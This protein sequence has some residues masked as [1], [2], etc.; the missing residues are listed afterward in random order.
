MLKRVHIREYRSLLDLEL[1][2]DDVSMISGANGVGKSNCYKALALLKS[3]AEGSFARFI[4]SEGGMESALWGGNT[5]GDKPRR[6]IITVE[7]SQFEYHVEVGVD[8]DPGNPSLF[9]MDPK[10]RV[11]KLKVHAGSS[12][13]LVGSRKAN[14]LQLLNS[15]WEFD[16]YEFP[17]VPSESFLSQVKEPAKFP[18]VSLVKQVLS[19]WRFYHEFDTS[20]RSPLRVPQ[21]AFWS[22]KL[23]D[24]GEN[25]ASVIQTI[26]EG[27]FKQD[28]DDIFEQAF[29][30][31][32]IAISSMQNRLELSVAQ[33]HLSRRLNLSE[34]SDGTLRFLC[35]AAA[36]L[37]L[38]KP[39]LIVLNEPEMSLNESVYPAIAKLISFA[40]RDSQ[41]IVVTHATELANS[42]RED[43]EL[44]HI[45]LA[46]DKGMTRLKDHVG[47]RRV[48][49]FD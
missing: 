35:L 39:D 14:Q 41:I 10:I 49:T 22:P 4:A 3:L 25:L 47:Q 33:T 13:R 18:F 17:V 1:R 20:S 8:S 34:V 36:L 15:E 29:S 45:E 37:S 24:D 2:F 12:S 11:E 42:V 7:H 46:L 30:D 19:S 48:W 6:I 23:E 31:M 9:L 27:G 5:K 28:F 44:T 38:D 16:Y 26:W 32:S 40:S 43:H 21:V